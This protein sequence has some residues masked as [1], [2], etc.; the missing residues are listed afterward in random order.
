M[1]VAF[2]IA[3]NLVARCVQHQ[4]RPA[5]P[6]D[7][8]AERGALHVLDEAAPDRDGAPAKVH[9]ARSVASD[10]VERVVEIMRHMAR[11]EGCAQRDDRPGGGDLSRRLQH[12]RPAQRMPDQQ[13]GRH[14]ARRQ[15]LGGADKVLHVRREG[16][17][18]ELPA[19]MPQPG[20]VEAQDGDALSRQAL[21]DP[22]RRDDVLAAGEAM[23][24]ERGGQV[25]PLRKVEP[26]GQRVAAMAGKGETFGGH[27]S[28]PSDAPED[29]PRGQV[30]QPA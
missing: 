19:G 20:E 17:V 24:E 4:E 6:R 2:S 8:L 26:R 25:R 30:R 5:E 7:V 15:R 3:H 1:R 12:R 18:A 28:S 29:G 13:R 27:G 10:V 16:G 22:P 14:A 11:I 23:G 21:R 9:L